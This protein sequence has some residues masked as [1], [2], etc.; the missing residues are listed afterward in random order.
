M[1]PMPSA[2]KTRRSVVLVGAGWVF[3]GSFASLT[4][5]PLSVDGTPNSS[6]GTDR[7]NAIR[8]PSGDHTSPETSQSGLVKGR[9]PPPSLSTTNSLAL[10][11][12]SRFE[13]KASLRPSGDHR[14]E[15][16]FGPEVY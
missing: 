3:V 11:S 2:L 8:V 4:S 9:A 5:S 15:P 16:S 7:R 14:G 6:V 12:V 13:K 1:K 10:P